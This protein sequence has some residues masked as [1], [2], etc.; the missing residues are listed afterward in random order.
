[1]QV[2]ASILETVFVYV[3]VAV[4]VADASPANVFGSTLPLRLS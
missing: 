1:M 2:A 3:R 4:A